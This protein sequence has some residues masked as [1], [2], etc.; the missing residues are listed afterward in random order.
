MPPHDT[1]PITVLMPVHNGEPYL[2]EAVKSILSQTAP[3]LIFLIIDDA[4]TDATPDILKTYAAQDKRFT[5]LRNE[6]VL[7]LTVSLNLG[8]ERVTT[9]YIARM[10]ADDVS[11]PQRLEKQ[12]AYMNAHPE[13]VALGS[14]VQAIDAAGEAANSPW[15][16]E[17]R[18][19]VRSADICKA[20]LLG[21]SVIVHPTALLRTD[22]LRAIGGYRACF[23]Y[24]QDYDLWLRLLPEGELHVLPEI[25]LQYR[26]H[27]QAISTTK[28]HEQRIAN[29][30]ALACALLRAWGK[31]DPLQNFTGPL[32]YTQLE[33]LAD[34]AGPIPWLRWLELN[35]YGHTSLTDED[36]CAI[37]EWILSF[38]SPE[39]TDRMYAN[40]AEISFLWIAQMQKIISTLKSNTLDQKEYIAL[41]LK[42]INEYTKQTNEHLKQINEYQK[43][44]AELERQKQ[45]IHTHYIQSTSWKVTAPMR[46]IANLFR[47]YKA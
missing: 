11:L 29:A 22:A 46:K 2:D 40:I 36:L 7:G 5:V 30:S 25:L 8:L 42:Q 41:Q 12:L 31:A 10:D 16:E 15:F 17:I 20:L 47:N 21:H 13:A 4:S 32:D 18:Q 37:N 43:H 1:P 23:R 9:P 35:S 3:D 14:W 38:S 45:D 28:L 34:K 39:S 33:Q 19:N 26:I 27:E 6:S 24:A 44:I